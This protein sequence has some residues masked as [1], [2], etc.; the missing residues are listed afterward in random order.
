MLKWP[1]GLPETQPGN[2][3]GADF[4][5]GPLATLVPNRAVAQSDPAGHTGS[6]FM[7]LRG[8]GE[9]ECD[10]K[11]VGAEEAGGADKRPSCGDREPEAAPGR[12]TPGFPKIQTKGPTV[13]AKTR[14][15]RK[16]QLS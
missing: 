15:L 5:P 1:L 14:R 6:P 11:G 10:E 9:Q 2:Q 3:V 4:M 8:G 12:A 16:G 13:W 7:F